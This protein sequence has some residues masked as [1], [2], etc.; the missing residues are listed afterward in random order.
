M[1]LDMYLKGSSFNWTNWKKPEGKRRPMSEG[2]EIEEEVLLLGYW[3]KHPNLHGYIVNTFAKGMDDCQQIDLT[4][5]DIENIIEAIKNNKLPTTLGFFFGKSD[6]SEDTESIRI[7]QDALKW[8]KSD[9]RN[10][11]KSVYYK[12]SW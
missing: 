6:G 4:E 9:K 1:G 12:A 7:L 2:F 3:R 10:K 8:L 11:S 5:E